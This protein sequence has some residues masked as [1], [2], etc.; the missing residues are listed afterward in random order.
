M[1]RLGAMV[2]NDKGDLLLHTCRNSIQQC[3]EDADEYFTP[4][5]W[6]KLKQLGCRVVSVEIDLLEIPDKPIK[7]IV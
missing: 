5:I 2:L 1:K 7:K 3:D 4:S 6:K